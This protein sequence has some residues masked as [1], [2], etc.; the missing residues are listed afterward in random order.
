VERPVLG[1]PLSEI[2]VRTLGG[3]VDR[4]VESVPG[5]AQLR[6]GTRAMLFLAR[7][8][9]AVVVSGMAQG[10]YPIVVEDAGVERLGTSPD[11]GSLIGPVGSTI[12]ARD[13]LVGTTVDEAA[14]IVRATRNA[15]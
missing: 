6:Q 5:E 7:E 13:R 12:G 2:W 8:G 15:P 9:R 3:R 1:E 14:G 10:H 4:A 11:A